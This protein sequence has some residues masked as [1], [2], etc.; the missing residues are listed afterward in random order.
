MTRTDL[1]IG[2]FGFGVV[3]QGLHAVLARTPGLYARIGRIAVKNRD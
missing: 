3:G 1:N 2:L